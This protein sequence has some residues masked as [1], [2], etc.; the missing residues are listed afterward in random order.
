[1]PIEGNAVA[2]GF[3]SKLKENVILATTPDKYFFNDQT[4]LQSFPS[5]LS[6][7]GIKLSFDNH[8]DNKREEG[9]GS[10]LEESLKSYESICDG[11][12]LFL[13]H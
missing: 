2:S 4:S 10:W 6:P 3:A 9:K 7:L 8:G 11:K 12:F 5:I 13:I 1:M